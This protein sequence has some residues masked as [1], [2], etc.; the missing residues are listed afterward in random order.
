MRPFKLSVGIV[1]GCLACS[2]L[3]Y[4]KAS[5]SPPLTACVVVYA[6]LLSTMVWRALARV[7]LFEVEELWTWTKLCSSFGA[8]LFM[9]S[10]FLIGVHRFVQPVPYEQILIMFT[11]YAAQLGI[12]LSVVDSRKARKE[13]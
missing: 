1:I 6:T 4:F 10:D 13:D 8:I 9:I 3:I 5:L 12:T 7:Q 11:Y 2:A